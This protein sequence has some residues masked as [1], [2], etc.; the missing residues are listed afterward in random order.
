[1]NKL[2]HEEKQQIYRSTISAAATV[3]CMRPPE[4]LPRAGHKHMKHYL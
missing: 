1:M 4:L 3:S 2:R